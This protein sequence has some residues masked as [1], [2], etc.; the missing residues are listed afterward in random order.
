MCSERR[1]IW[2]ELLLP[3][4]DWQP[5]SVVPSALG[6]SVM[7][8]SGHLALLVHP[9]GMSAA[10]SAEATG[11]PRPTRVRG[12]TEICAE[13]QAPFSPEAF[14]RP[15]GALA[16]VRIVTTPS[17]THGPQPRRRPA[18]RPPCGPHLQGALSPRPGPPLLPLLP[19]LRPR[20]RGPG[21][22]FGRGKLQHV[23]VARRKVDRWRVHSHPPPLLVPGWR[24]V[25]TR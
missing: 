17:A 9:D 20:S 6:S 2:G 10:G 25:T 24:A 19:W 1:V 22:R 4:G 13:G 15:P 21:A 14:Q 8:P 5:H 11:W 23:P 12:D 18:P 3:C 7:T 16:Q